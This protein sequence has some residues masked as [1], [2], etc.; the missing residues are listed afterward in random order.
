M[1]HELDDQVQYVSGFPFESPTMWY[2]F[3]FAFRGG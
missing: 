3:S 1:H 2:N